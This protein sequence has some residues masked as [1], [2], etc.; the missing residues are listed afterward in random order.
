MQFSTSAIL[1][2][3]AIFAGQTL[4]ACQQGSVNSDPM[5]FQDCTTSDQL[6]WK[7]PGGVAVSRTTKFHVAAK[8]QRA[9]VRISCRRQP[10]AYLIMTCPRLQSGDFEQ[11]LNCIPIDSDVDVKVLLG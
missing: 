5:A 6:I 4:A 11:Y 1:A 3:V 8:S 2:A 7:C 10:Q 9:A